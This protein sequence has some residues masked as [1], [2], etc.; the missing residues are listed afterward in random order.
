MGRTEVQVSHTFYLQT[1]AQRKQTFNYCGTTGIL[2]TK[3]TNPLYSAKLEIRSDA[4]LKNLRKY[5]EYVV[6]KRALLE[7]QLYSNHGAWF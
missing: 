1:A 4:D 3:I 7:C 2:C 5:S 6:K